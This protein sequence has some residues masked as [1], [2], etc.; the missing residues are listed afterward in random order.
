[1]CNA[2][3]SSRQ[4]T[5]IAIRPRYR[6]QTRRD[7]CVGPEVQSKIDAGNVFDI[8][9][10]VTEVIDALI[11]NGNLDSD[12]RAIVAYTG[13]GLGLRSGVRK[14]DISSE[15]ALKRTL[16]NAASI[17]LSRQG[18]GA[19]RFRELLVQLDIGDKVVP[20]LIELEDSEL[21]DA[22]M[23]HGAEMIVGAISNLLKYGATVVR[24][25]EKFQIKL[26]FAAAVAI[27]ATQAEAAKAL[28]HLL[29]IAREA[30]DAMEQY[31]MKPGA[32]L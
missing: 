27:R 15:A 29:S 16:L 32:P 26:I 5:A 18:R 3:G 21:G 23:T 30:A 2:D 20:K 12:S 10:S 31:G 8:A 25:P 4:K 1:M 22:F 17:A 11:Q 9:I 6:A 13:L 19:L 24:F 28:I 14:P 7:V